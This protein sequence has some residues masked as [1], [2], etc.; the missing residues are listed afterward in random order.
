MC[1]KSSNCNWYLI[2]T[3]SIK[4]NNAVPKK[5]GK[6]L[7][8]R[9]YRMG[10][11]GYSYIRHRGWVSCDP[12]KREEWIILAGGMGDIC[13]RFDCHLEHLA[14]SEGP[15]SVEESV[16]SSHWKMVPSY[17]SLRIAVSSSLRY[18]DSHRD[19]NI[20]ICQ[21]NYLQHNLR[22]TTGVA[23]GLLPDLISWVDV[24]S[25]GNHRNM[26]KTEGI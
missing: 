8:L 22:S 7:S 12:P 23:G 11:P 6:I 3:E 4:V 2:R 16:R 9:V 15:T 24:H 5:D 26:R 21:R 14:S 19:R 10:L 17:V 13:V 20:A 18:Y 1:S 25:F